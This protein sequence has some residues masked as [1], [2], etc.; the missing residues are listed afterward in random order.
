MPV[1]DMDM[2]TAMPTDMGGEAATDPGLKNGVEQR[3][4]AEGCLPPPQAR[5][6]HGAGSMLPVQQG[7]ESV[8]W[9]RNSEDLAP[10]GVPLLSPP[11]PSDVVREVRS[12][13]IH[14]TLQMVVCLHPPPAGF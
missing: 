7:V 9:T 11:G 3:V 2:D 10:H 5:G 4:L 1:R 12:V 14:K 13:P 8:P 6:G